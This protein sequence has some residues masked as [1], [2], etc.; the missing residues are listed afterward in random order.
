MLP[1]KRKLNE[2]GLLKPSKR[3]ALTALAV[4]MGVCGALYCLPCTAELFS[5]ATQWATR[6]SRPVA[7][8]SL[9]APPA[10]TVRLARPRP[11]VRTAGGVARASVG[12]AA[13]A[14]AVA[15]RAAARPTAAPAQQPRPSCR[16][17]ALMPQPSC[18]AF[19]RS[20]GSDASVTR[21]H[22]FC[23]RPGSP[24]LRP[25]LRRLPAAASLR[26]TCYL[27]LVTCCLLLVTC[28]VLRVRLPAAAHASPLTRT[29]LFSLLGQCLP[30]IHR[31][32]PNDTHGS[33]H[34]GACCCRAARC[35]C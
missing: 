19:L 31:R 13:P 25:H 3:A 32:A 14:V 12:A 23:T 4:L 26:V 28:C 16:P 9:S 33:S 17:E 29:R 8:A 1:S 34:A 11:S 18:A 22:P 2:R 21:D 5:L 15:V 10:L 35:R 6:S 20:L 30:I 24:A 27:L 7:L